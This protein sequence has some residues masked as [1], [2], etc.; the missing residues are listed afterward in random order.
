[1]MYMVIM[2]Y[3][4][5][6]VMFSFSL[7]IYAIDFYVFT[8]DEDMEVT[9]GS[10]PLMKKGVSQIKL[11]QLEKQL[12]I[13]MKVK[14]GA[15]NMIRM[16]THSSRDRKLYNEAQKMLGDSKIKVEVL[17]MQI[18]KARTAVSQSSEQGESESETKG[19]SILLSQEARINMLRY[20]IGVESSVIQGA[21][22][23]MKVNP[24]GWQ[25]VGII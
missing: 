20:R 14:A 4:C 12:S 8:V 17:R 18:M 10:P 7:Y 11:D 21:K 1:M 6:N 15:E 24:K 25:T 9:P 16:Y 3:I 13:E 19:S 5:C 23:I 2:R 22:N